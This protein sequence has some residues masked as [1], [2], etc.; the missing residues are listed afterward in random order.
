VAAAAAQAHDIQHSALSTQEV[1][2]ASALHVSG[3]PGR[4]ST[5]TAGDTNF[6]TGPPDW[7][8]D[9]FGLKLHLEALRAAV[10]CGG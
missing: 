2:R 10:S 7:T 6:A 8:L 5:G 1:M 9:R 3:R 4:F